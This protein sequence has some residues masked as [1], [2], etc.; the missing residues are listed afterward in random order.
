MCERDSFEPNLPA[1]CSDSAHELE[2]LLRHCNA[3]AI[4]YVRNGMK[5]RQDYSPCL[6]PGFWLAVPDEWRNSWAGE[7]DA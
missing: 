5:R 6:V 2:A 1:M 3:Q 7:G 4:D